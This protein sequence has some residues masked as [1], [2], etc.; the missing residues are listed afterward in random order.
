M[1]KCPSAQQLIK[2]Y[3]SKMHAYRTLY[4]LGRVVMSEKNKGAQ[5]YPMLNPLV[6]LLSFGAPK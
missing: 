5:H 6:L 4:L 1:H 2:I 3:Q